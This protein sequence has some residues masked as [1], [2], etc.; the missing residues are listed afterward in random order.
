VTKDHKE[1]RKTTA[2]K[3]TRGAAE[4]FISD[5]REPQAKNVRR[6]FHFLLAEEMV[7]GSATRVENLVNISELQVAF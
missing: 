4:N 5:L 1:Y 6:F 3:Q 2:S 7:F